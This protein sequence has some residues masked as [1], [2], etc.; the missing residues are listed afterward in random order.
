MARLENFR[1]R[2][3][4]SVA[5]HLSFRKAAEHLFI[6][7]PAVT[8]QIKALESDL[9]VQLFDRRSGRVTLTQHGSVLLGYANKIAVIVAQAERELSSEHAITGE[10]SLGVSTT[11]A[12]Y[13]LPRLLGTF[14]N[15]YPRVQFSLRSGNT[16]E[17]VQ[18]LLG[19]KISVGLIEGPARD[20]DTRDANFPQGLGPPYLSGGAE[21]DLPISP[22]SC[23]PTGV[24]PSAYSLNFTA[25]PYPGHGAR[26]G[27][28]E[29]WPTGQKPQ[30]PVS[31]L[32]NPTGTNVANAAIVSAGTNGNITTFVSNDTHLAI[33]IDGFAPPGVGGLSLYP[34]IPCRVFDSR[35]SGTGQ[36]FS[37]QLSPPVDV[38]SSGCGAPSTAQAYVLNAT[39]VPS[40]QMGYLTLWPD[41]DGQPIVSTLNAA[42][43]LTTS[44]MAIVPNHNGKVDAYAAAPTQLILDISSYFAP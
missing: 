43:G 3:F 5:E 1:L 14:L 44:N 26:L 39:V 6:S 13:V 16:H 35:S 34:T 33:D 32:N 19:G 36:P 23:I 21:R 17:V 40:G 18:L 41:P 30:N 28:L 11:I 9:G 29:I 2:V 31:T 42:D 10:F 27:Y 25:I 12:Q 20:A 22:S 4:R 37:G 8:L 38:P 24:S 7:Q 15:E